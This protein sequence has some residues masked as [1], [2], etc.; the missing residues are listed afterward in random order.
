MTAAQKIPGD[1][2]QKVYAGLIDSADNVIGPSNPLAVL[3]PVSNS[4]VPSSYDYINLAY[5][6][7]SNLTTAIFRTGGSGGTAVST[8]VLTYDGSNN[9]LT[10]TQS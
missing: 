6:G 5:D 2:N 7:S 3:D 8:L 9:L 10:V 1:R 4:L